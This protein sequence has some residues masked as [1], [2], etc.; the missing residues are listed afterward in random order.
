MSIKK[1]KTSFRIKL[2][3]CIFVIAA[4]IFFALTC[5]GFIR[6]NA[7]ISG[8]PSVV[9]A[10]GLCMDDDDTNAYIC[11]FGED[12][13]GS[14]LPATEDETIIYFVQQGRGI[15]FLSGLATIV[16]IKVVGSIATIASLLGGLIYWIHNRGK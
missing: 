3:T 7:Y 1:H 11:G 13:N 2:N 9:D 5:V 16:A 12:E 14:P 4:I 8:M 10:P 6:A 15:T